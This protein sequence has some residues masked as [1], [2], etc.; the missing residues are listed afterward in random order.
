MSE[1]SFGS[2]AALLV[3]G[4]LAYFVARWLSTVAKANHAW[5][6]ILLVFIGFAASIFVV[7]VN[8][9]LSQS[10]FR[11]SGEPVPLWVALLAWLFRI[12]PLFMLV[13]HQLLP[14]WRKRS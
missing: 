3:V 4:A 8:V 12:L 2:V 14:E 6:L 9:P 1:S 11:P 10:H 13:V 7:D 5:V